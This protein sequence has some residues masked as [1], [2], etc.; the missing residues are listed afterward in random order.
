[1]LDEPTSGLN[2]AG[3]RSVINGIR[4]I[5][6]MA[7]IVVATHDEQ[8]AAFADMRIDLSAQTR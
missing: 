6:P 4:S 5:L 1:L 3:S 2:C 7:T 8:V